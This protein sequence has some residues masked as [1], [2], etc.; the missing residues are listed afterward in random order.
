MW[1]LSPDLTFVCDWPSDPK[2]ITD[3]L[4]AKFC[5]TGDVAGVLRDIL[6][7]ASA[8]DGHERTAS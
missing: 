8:A 4:A 1:P 7:L 6:R 2:D 3:E 5:E